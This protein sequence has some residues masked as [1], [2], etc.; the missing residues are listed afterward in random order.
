MLGGFFLIY[1]PSTPSSAACGWYSPLTKY[2]QT[3]VLVKKD[4]GQVGKW[5]LAVL[6]PTPDLPLIMPKIPHQIFSLLLSGSTWKVK[7]SPI[8]ASKFVLFNCFVHVT[9]FIPVQRY[10]LDSH[11]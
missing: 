11:L 5:V 10:P 3:K 2:M 7:S 9:T 6:E 8:P 4:K 1:T